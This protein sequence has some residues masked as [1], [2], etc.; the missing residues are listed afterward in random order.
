MGFETGLSGLDANSR[1]L[2]A[3][4]NNVANS[5]V[6]GF[7]QSQL[8]FADI[9]ATSLGGG[10]SNTQVGLGTQVA[11]VQQQFAQGSIT[12]TSNPLDLAINGGGFFK[13]ASTSGTVTY[14]RNG[15][16]NESKDG[17]IVNA[18][19]QRLQGYVADT[20]TG[21]INTASTQDIILPT[22]SI[23]SK[24][25]QTV[26][27]EANLNA[28]ATTPAVS[29]FNSANASSYNNVASV[30]IID[31]IGKSHTVSMYFS[32]SSTVANGWDVNYTLDN[33]NAV[34]PATSPLVFD[35]SGRLSSPATGTVSLS[36]PVATA[37]LIPAS[38][39]TVSIDVTGVT[40]F[41]GQAFGVTSNIQ[42]GYTSG[43]LTGFNVGSDGKVAGTY[44]NG[45]TRDIAQVVVS[46]F[47]SPEGLTP[48]GNN[49]WVESAASGQPAP[50][51]PGTGVAG[52]LQSSSL[53]QSNVDLTKELVNMIVAQRS[54]QANAQTIKTQDQILS[55]LVNLR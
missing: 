47:R 22:T 33:G 23:D 32:K 3:I 19:G 55:T 35:T 37:G 28:D 46:T 29:P 10:G 1:Y 26:T 34:T 44:T 50:A 36:L 6:A 24:A 7:K 54:Y 15:Q 8:S 38:P 53:E 9:Y 20:T 27:L 21:L 5:N 18:Q 52:V 41:G 48:I 13:L 31:S 40:Q 42:D 16:F 30:N 14:T 4:G 39:Q 43:R 51:V 17:Y 12:S 49:Q 11:A 2:D 45:V 25:T